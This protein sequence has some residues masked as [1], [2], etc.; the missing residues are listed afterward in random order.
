MELSI[1]AIGAEGPPIQEPRKLKE[2]QEAK[3]GG[4]SLSKPPVKE[5]M[6]VN[7]IPFKLRG[8]SND[9]SSEKKDAPQERWPRKL[10][11]K[12]MQA[13]QCP[14]LDSDVSRIF[15]DLLNANL[16]ELPDMKRPEEVGKTDDPNTA[17]T[18]N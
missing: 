7:T 12:E 11:L 17:S 6:V 4:K 3:R 2:K 15:D 13:K 10:T 8:K 18:I 16:I 9:M 1:A 5:A 14:F